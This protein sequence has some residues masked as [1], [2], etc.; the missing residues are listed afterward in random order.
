MTLLVGP[1]GCGKTTLISIIAGLLEPADGEVSVL[2]TRLTTLSGRQAVLFRGRKISFVFRQYNLL[3]ALMAAENAANH[4]YPL[5]SVRVEPFV[6]P[7]R[8]L[9]GEGTERTD[10]RVLKI[11]YALDR[12]NEHVFVGQQLDVFIEAIPDDRGTLRAMTQE[13][14]R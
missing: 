11:I 5:E 14:M 3:P 13:E 1:S 8:S 4:T 6:V 12:A 7:K 9:T 2:G 10:T